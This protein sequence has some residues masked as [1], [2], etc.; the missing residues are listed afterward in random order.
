MADT[1][2]KLDIL[3]CALHREDISLSDFLSLSINLDKDRLD[4]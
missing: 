4:V 2:E 3:M 1:V